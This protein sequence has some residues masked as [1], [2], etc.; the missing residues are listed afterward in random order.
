MSNWID[1]YHPEAKKDIDKL[2]G[3]QKIAVR[4]AIR[5]VLQNPLPQSEG[6]FG[7]P[8][9]NKSRNN[10]TSLLK[11]KL[12]K[13]GLRIVYKVIRTENIMYVLV[14]GVRSDNEVYNI[15]EERK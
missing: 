3:S 7:K 11:V 10:L 9:G 15:A 12:K 2:D 14:V 8:L 5:K 13:E 4:K 6:G 1:K